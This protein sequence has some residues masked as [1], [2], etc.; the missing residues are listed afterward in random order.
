MTP[1]S[2]ISYMLFFEWEMNPDNGSSFCPDTFL[3][4]RCFSFFYGRGSMSHFLE[5]LWLYKIVETIATTT[6]AL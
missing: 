5:H 2:Q 4:L 6:V 1:I 3:P